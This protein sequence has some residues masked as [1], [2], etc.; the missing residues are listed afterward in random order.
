MY[1]AF[2]N[3]AICSDPKL[4]EVTNIP[5]DT[6]CVLSW[7]NLS[8]SH[9]NFT[10]YWYVTESRTPVDTDPIPD[11]YCN[12]LEVGTW[13]DCIQYFPHQSAPIYAPFVWG[14]V[15]RAEKFPELSYLPIYRS[16]ETGKYDFEGMPIK[17]DVYTIVTMNNYTPAIADNPTQKNEYRTFDILNYKTMVELVRE[18]QILTGKTF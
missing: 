10:G 9:S 13:V 3:T 6:M 15:I 11:V 5:S 16:V 17:E 4:W 14:E 8:L 18:L 2:V 1:K 7:E 12:L